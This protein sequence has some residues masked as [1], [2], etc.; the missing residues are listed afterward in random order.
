MAQKRNDSGLVGVLRHE[1]D[2]SGAVS[3]ASSS[4]NRTMLLGDLVYSRLFK[5]L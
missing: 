5:D 1:N 4:P 3:Q 2:I